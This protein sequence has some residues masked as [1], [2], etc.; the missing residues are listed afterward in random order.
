MLSTTFIRPGH[1]ESALF[2]KGYSILLSLND[3]KSVTHFASAR[4]A[5][6]PNPD[7]VPD[8]EDPFRIWQAWNKAYVNCAYQE[9]LETP[10]A[11]ILRKLGLRNFEYF[12]QED[13][14][15]VLKEIYN[16]ETMNIVVQTFDISQI[17]GVGFWKDEGRASAAAM[18]D[19]LLSIGISPPFV[20]ISL[21]ESRKTEGFYAA[22]KESTKRR[23]K[24]W[25]KNPHPCPIS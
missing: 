24:N 12:E 23:K 19:K 9:H 7:R 8:M 6:F 14:Q 3:K 20:R 15:I 1:S 5:N 2:R 10:F 4:D 18:H 16:P 22:N 11:N 25:K 21:S 17:V 13:T